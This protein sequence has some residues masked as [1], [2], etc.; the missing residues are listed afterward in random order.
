MATEAA[1]AVE[2]LRAR[3]DLGER[4]P[5]AQRLLDVSPRFSIGP[6]VLEVR[7]GRRRRV[8]V[9]TSPADSRSCATSST[10][11]PSSRSSSIRRT[12]LSHSLGPMPRKAADR[13]ARV[14]AH[15][16]RAR[17]PLLGGG[18]VGVADAG[19]RPDRA[20]RRRAGR[21]RPSCT[22]TSRSPRRSSSRASARS[23]RRG[24]ASS[25]SA[26]NFPS[27]RY[28][29]QAQPDLEVVVCE[30]DEE[31]VER[32]TSAR[33]SSRSATCSSRRRRS[34]TSSRSCA[35]RTRSART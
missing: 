21:D 17:D 22:R 19:R 12:S 3:L 24:T 32:S 5:A 4:R 8:P 35:A 15:V 27:V 10:T 14:R 18:L 11:A 28:L 7:L 31:I 26:A 25:T 33:C 34:R 13:L 20:H 23:I 9:A 30:D 16:G 1:R 6:Y 2:D 29:Y